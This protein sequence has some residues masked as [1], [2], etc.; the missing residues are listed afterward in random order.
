MPTRIAAQ[1][2]LNPLAEFFA[3]VAAGAP[4]TSALA[5]PPQAL[6]VEPNKDL[7]VD[8]IKRHGFKPPS[9]LHRSDMEGAKQIIDIFVRTTVYF[10]CH[11]NK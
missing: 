5:T 6:F 3:E 7:D 8:T 4:S 10:R 11:E 9:E 1:V 2:K